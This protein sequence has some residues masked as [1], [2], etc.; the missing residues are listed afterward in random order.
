MQTSS[1]FLDFLFILLLATLFML[2]RSSQLGALDAQPAKAGAGHAAAV[3]SS[4]VVPLAVTADALIFKGQTYATLD[5]LPPHARP[6]AHG[7]I[8]LVPHTDD[9]THHR[10]MAVWTQ[11]MDRGWPVQLGVLRQ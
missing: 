11:L 6:E 10:L 8:L 9:L 3:H 1:A 5:D 4:D 2:S 7:T